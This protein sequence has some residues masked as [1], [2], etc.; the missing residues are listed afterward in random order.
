[1][2]KKFFTNWKKSSDADLM[3]KEKETLITQIDTVKKAVKSPLLFMIIDTRNEDLFKKGSIPN[4]KNLPQADVMVGHKPRSL[5]D[6]REAFH[7][8]SID[9]DAF[10]E[11]SYII[12]Y[13]NGSSAVVKAVIEHYRINQKSV[14]IFKGGM[15]EW[16]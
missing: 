4:A 5:L 10:Q 2:T 6:I 9:Y 12:L 14:L 8:R 13:G 7:L 15:A 11:A 1:L 16:I 3:I